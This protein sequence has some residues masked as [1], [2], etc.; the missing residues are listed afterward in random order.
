MTNYPYTT[1]PGKISTLFNKIQIV[2]IPDRVTTK[3]LESLGFTGSN[4]RSLLRLLKSLGFI[5]KSGTP[6]ER[7]RLFRDR[8][9]AGKVLAAALREAYKELFQMYPDAYRQDANALSNFFRSH[10]SGGERSNSLM[11]S[12][13]QELCKLADFRDD[14]DSV[15]NEV[16]ISVDT[17]D[18]QTHS[19]SGIQQPSEHNETSLVINV[20]IQLV[21]PDQAD[22]ETYDRLFTSLRRH[23]LNGSHD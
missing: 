5:D 16:A 1:V 15:S 10:T 8:N 4:D 13:F 18:Y 22:S 9:Q 3:Y 23:L 6:Q 11:V 19:R 20:N 12:T 7:W 2:G 17:H 21:L 14:S